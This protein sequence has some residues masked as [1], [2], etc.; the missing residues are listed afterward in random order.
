[1]SGSLFWKLAFE[2]W[3]TKGSYPWQPSSAKTVGMIFE[4]HSIRFGGAVHRLS[5][6][7][8]DNSKHGFLRIRLLQIVCSNVLCML[9]HNYLHQAF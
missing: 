1:M 8:R 6:N 3:S 4:M 5:T 9:P 7:F 2:M